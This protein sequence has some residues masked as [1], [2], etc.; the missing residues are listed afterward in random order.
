LCQGGVRA[1]ESSLLHTK[2]LEYDPY[3]GQVFAGSPQPKVVNAKLMSLHA[4]RGRHLNFFLA[5]GDRW[6]LNHGRPSD[7]DYDWLHPE[8]ADSDNPGNKLAATLQAVE[9]STCL[10]MYED[11]AHD[12]NMHGG[13]ATPQGVRHALI[14]SCFTCMPVEFVKMFSG[15]KLDDHSAVDEYGRDA[16]KAMLQPS[17]CVTGG[18]SPPRWGVCGM[19]PKPASLDAILRTGADAAFLRDLIGDF[20]HLNSAT[21]PSFTCGGDLYVVL[22]VSF[23]TIVQYKQERVDAKEM[24]VIDQ[25]LHASFNKVK[26]DHIL[27]FN[28]DAGGTYSMW[29]DAV[30]SQHYTDN[31]HLT[32]PNVDLG[33][34]LAPVI[35]AFQEQTSA[36]QNITVAV[37]R[38][39]H[40]VDHLS[41]RVAWVEASLGG[42][43]DALSSSMANLSVSS[44]PV[45][46][47]EAL[48]TSNSPLELSGTTNS[49]SNSATP[50]GVPNIH[51]SPS[52]GPSLSPANGP[53]LGFVSR[54]LQTNPLA[55]LTFK[56]PS[57][58]TSYSNKGVSAADYFM[59]Y[60]LR[61][62]QHP[63]GIKASDKTRSQK[64]LDIYDRVLTRQ[65]RSLFSVGNKTDE[66]DLEHLAWDVSDLI[67]SRLAFSFESASVDVPRTLKPPSRKRKQG[68]SQ[69][70]KVILMVNAI[71]D[72]FEDLKKKNI[73][74]DNSTEAWQAY[75]ISNPLP[76]REMRTVSQ[77]LNF[78]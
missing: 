12:A 9:T 37:T 6:A 8:L 49:S 43:I 31:L 4:S 24:L 2:N 64:C 62:C 52:N 56:P 22:E 41:T 40:S 15:H 11:V 67:V 34:E 27:Y 46:D 55:L 1:A 21:P 65:E 51:A 76:I 78:E 47:E 18:Y 36:L 3:Y 14:S 45:S 60:H 26:R 58:T 66:G 59:G 28:A 61:S 35:K 48:S 25:R 68:S 38:L 42:K 13:K 44:I 63:E 16:Q 23:A 19:G 30:K 71:E 74:F 20:F 10:K 5:L 77:V 75:R 70:P 73:S 53:P 72:R 69:S 57:E 33:E 50:A 29:A 39:H 7:D 17:T 54:E 32:S